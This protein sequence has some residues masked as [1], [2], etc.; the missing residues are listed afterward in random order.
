[1]VMVVIASYTR[2]A[3][4]S[5]TMSFIKLNN[6][7]NCLTNIWFFLLQVLQS[8]KDQLKWSLLKWCL[9]ECGLLQVL[10]FPAPLLFILLSANI[11]HIKDCEVYSFILFQSFKIKICVWFFVLRSRCSSISWSW[12]RQRWKGAIR[13]FDE[14]MFLELWCPKMILKQCLTEVLVHC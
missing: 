14:V 3:I 9:M 10:W 1:M 4:V 6:Y 2:L 5:C 12:R 8:A 11:Y 13:P 7:I